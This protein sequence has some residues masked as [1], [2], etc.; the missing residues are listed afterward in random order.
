MILGR[1]AEEVQSQVLLYP[2]PP[3]CSDLPQRMKVEL[4]SF[5]TLGDLEELFSASPIH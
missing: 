5:L 2:P 4:S 3:A 1:T